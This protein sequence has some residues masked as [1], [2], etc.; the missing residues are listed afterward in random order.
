MAKHKFK[1]VDPNPNF[2]KLEEE[3]LASWS[4]S[5]IFEKS[6]EQRKGKKPFIFFEGPPTANV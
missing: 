2:P 4:K 6:V 3:V 5:K 1:P